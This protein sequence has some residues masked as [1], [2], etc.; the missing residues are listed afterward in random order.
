MYVLY[1]H[2]TKKFY[3]NPYEIRWKIHEWCKN[4]KFS[5]FYFNEQYETLVKFLVACPPQCVETK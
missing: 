4:A 3:R 2:D 1:T 5:S